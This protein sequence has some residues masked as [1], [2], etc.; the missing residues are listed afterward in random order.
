[1]KHEKKVILMYPPGMLFQRGEDRC[2]SNINDSTATTIRACNDLGYAASMLKKRGFKPFLKD[3]QTEGLKLKMLL[4]D[5][6]RIN[7]DVLFFSTTNATIFDDLK[8]ISLLKNIKKDFI[9]LLKGAIFFN[10]PDD[11]LNQLNLKDIDY[12]IGGE[13]DFITSELVYS[14]FNDK[15][16]IKSIKGIFYKQNNKWK[17]TGFDEWEQDLDKLSFPDRSLMNN[18]LY[19][20]P[21][22]NEPMA[23]ISTSRGC[24][25]SCIYCLT[26]IISGRKIRL[27]N[28]ENILEELKDCYN[29]YNIRNFFFKSDT[30]TMYKDWVIKLCD[31]IKNSELNNKIEWVTNSRAKPLELETLKSMKKAGCWLIGFGFE[32][33]SKK[34]LE[35]I[36]KG[37]TIEDNIR[38]VKLCRKVGL[39]VF[40]FYM[41]GF[42][43][44]TKTD[45]N[46]TKKLMYKLNTDFVEL[47]IATPFYGTELYNLVKEAGLIDK[48]VL[49][50]D[51]FNTPTI[52][53]KYVPIKEI[54][55]YRDK[56]LF[57]Y[58]IRPSFILKHIGYA[59]KSP[60]ITKA[61]FHYGLKIIKQNLLGI[62]K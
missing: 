7:P 17:P 34:T 57:R 43:W 41:I 51:Y 42:P 31:L 49:G 60:K 39:K 27:R 10:T 12:L 4:D 52:G 50:K 6:K 54:I 1:M 20:R 59:I 45:F 9:V 47:H 28:P 48:S 21:D 46:S 53:T 11:V 44:E 23:T 33:G 32:S 24:P 25:S 19:V 26:P 30:F 15:N 55:K 22:T 8:V 14:H 18:N 29:N 58:H 3:Y 56:T 37:A 40:G 62:G 2:Q 36:K 61:Y 13:S 5:F 35:S 16:N 38:A